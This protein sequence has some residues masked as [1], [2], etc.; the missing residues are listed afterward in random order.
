MWCAGVGLLLLATPL[1]VRIYTMNVALG[2][3][4]ETHSATLTAHALARSG[5]IHLD[6]YFPH[7]RIPPD[8]EYA[9]PRRGGH[10]VGCEPLVSSMTFA[11]WF[12]P[13]RDS[14]IWKGKLVWIGNRIA[15]V[16][17]AF[18]TVLLGA[19]LLTLVSFPR[20]LAVTAIV[21][22]ATSHRTI[23][24]AGLWTH[25]AAAPWL[26]AG[27]FLWSH[28]RGR[29]SFYPF[30][31]AALTLAAAC[32]TVLAP[33][34]ILALADAWRTNRTRPA[35]VLFA[36][37]AVSL[38]AAT[39]L[40][41]NWQVH[42]SWLGGRSDIVA[43]IAATHAVTAYFDFSLMHLVGILFSPSRGLF[44]Y[45]PVLLFALPGV[46]RA[47]GAESRGVLAMITLAGVATLAAHAFVATW[48]GGWVFGPRYMTDLL[49]F[50]ALWLALAPLPRQRRALATAAFLVALLWSLGV[51]QLGALTY[52]CDWNATPIPIDRAPARLWDW[53]DSQLARCATRW[54]DREPVALPGPE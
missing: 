52:P 7:G 29:P 43:N 53:R 31:T 46:V 42:G 27:L 16:I 10:I 50:F 24:G 30:A 17:A 2:L 54:L 41:F 34:A 12:L 28:A 36:T 13:Y 6:E 40:G 18:T 14:A 9:F 5:S 49:P 37:A 33:V 32:R 25:T 3:V 39:A 22:L 23:T 20:A 51:Q 26:V 21:A 47:F 44:I 15:A 35:I 48:W 19:W 11:P 4:P 8:L 1:L 45:S 38:I